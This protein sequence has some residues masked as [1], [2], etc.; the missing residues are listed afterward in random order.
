MQQLG[1]A[2]LFIDEDLQEGVCFPAGK[3]DV[4]VYS[5]RSPARETGNEDA[6][7]VIPYNSDTIVLAVADGAG[8]M[9]A[10]AQASSLTINTLQAALSQAAA[11]SRDSREAILNGIEQA[12][13]AV[14][15]LGIGASTTLAVAE[16]QGRSVR[17][18]H[19]GDSEILLV[20]QRGKIKL[21][22]I[23][24][25]PV[26]YAV[27]AGLLDH[28]EAIHH[29]ERHLVSNMIG[30]AEMRIEIG[31]ATLMAPRDTLLL[32]S[33][34]LFDNLHVGEIID[35]IRHGAVKKAAE[36]LIHSCRQRMTA[37]GGD[38]PSKPDDLTFILYRQK[39]RAGK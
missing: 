19:I 23:S 20:G 38:N 36:K 13:Q 21:Q 35:H 22:T 2:R 15:D 17:S 3:G 31:P 33:D 30:H 14:M 26:G 1:D 18:Y 11:D 6:A 29:E 34:G 37:P 8:G 28:A 12:N 7:A 16:L 32:A 10:G 5:S 39:Y 9:R 4:L 25:S 24:H 27:E